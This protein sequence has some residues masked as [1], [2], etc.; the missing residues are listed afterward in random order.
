M[1]SSQELRE[2]SKQKS[3]PT[4][5]DN[6]RFRREK[7]FLFDIML[8]QDE[9]TTSSKVVLPYLCVTSYKF[10]C[11][12]FSNIA[13]DNFIR[14]VHSLCATLQNLVYKEK[15]CEQHCH[16]CSDRKYMP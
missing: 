1:F 11:E 13:R 7:R 9:T 5:L 12:K 6:L 4:L 2:N 16:I 3:L 15:R 8:F 14:G 10:V